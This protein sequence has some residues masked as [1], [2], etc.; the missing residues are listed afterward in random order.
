[1][2]KPLPALF[3]CFRSVRKVPILLCTILF[4]SDTYF[5]T[6]YLIPDVSYLLPVEFNIKDPIKSQRKHPIPFRGEGHGRDNKEE[7]GNSSES[8]KVS[9]GH[10]SKWKESDRR[11]QNTRRWRRRFTRTGQSGVIADVVG[12]R[13]PVL[14]PRRP[15]FP[16]FLQ[17]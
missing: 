15:C 16:T 10:Q 3:D 9:G 12:V 4:W 1:M 14:I 2:I 7:E 13:D 8:L 6:F 11:R 5:L 17:P